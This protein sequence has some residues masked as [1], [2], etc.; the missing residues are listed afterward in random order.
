MSATSSGNQPRT[1]SPGWV[2]TLVCAAQLLLQLDFSIVNVAL[3][4]IQR[5]L[6]FTAASLQWVVTGYALAYGSLL[7]LGGRVGDLLGHRRA[8]LAGLTVFA[9]ASLA[10]GL[11]T[12][13]AM[14]VASR[15]VQGAGAALVAP[16]ALATLTAAYP[17][18]TARTRA[19]GVFQASIAA[20]ATAGIVLGGVLVEFLGWR[21]VLLVNPPVLAVLLP[22]MVRR[23]PARGPAGGARLD[24]T[25]AVLITTALVAVVLGTGE[26]EHHGFTSVRVLAE[27]AVAAV[28]LGAFVVTERRVRQPMVPL[29]LFRDRARTGSL[30]V[31]LLL[32]AVVA[33]YVYFVALYLQEVLHISAL[34]TGLGLV[35]ATVTV[36]VFSTVLSRRLLPRLGVRRMLVL[37]VP[38]TAAGQLW[39]S[40]IS[41]DG[42]YL[43]DV[44]PGLLLTAAGMGLAL[45]TASVAVTAAVPPELRGVAGGL[46]VTAQQA[47]AAIGLAVL[48]SVAAARSNNAGATLVDGYRMSYLVGA[49]IA[50]VAAVLALLLIREPAKP[51]V[52]S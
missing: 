9:L 33:G 5:D 17:S 24:V 39:F 41:A 47:G 28:L 2:L 30:V 23:L 50:L 32:G 3:S 21:A 22:L 40:Q 15:F 35:P 14:L 20:G 34:R 19:L 46:L 49:G 10:G 7:L 12:S 44:L 18:T 38:V 48:A 4:A 37:A 52:D 27:L 45:P 26:G 42:T 36:M 51:A 31:V 25:G 8:M 11:A 16:A 13:P 43:V 6:G 1:S 29:S